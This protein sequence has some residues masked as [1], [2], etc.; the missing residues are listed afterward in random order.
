MWLACWWQANAFKD[1]RKKTI[2]KKRDT[3]VLSRGV[4]ER[5]KFIDNSFSFV[6]KILKENQ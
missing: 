2:E 3:D 6:M 5:G 4:P 1:N